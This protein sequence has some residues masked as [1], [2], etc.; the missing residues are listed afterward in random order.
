MLIIGFLLGCPLFH[1]A[2]ELK[3]VVETGD[4]N[5]SA[6]VLIVANKKKFND[7]VILKVTRMLRKEGMHVQLA[8]GTNLKGIRANKYGAIIIINFIEDK[9][10][11]RSIE[12]FADERVQK[13]IVLF[14][15]VGDY[16]TSDKDR[17]SSKTEKSEKI[18]L[19]IIERTKIILS[20]QRNSAEMRDGVR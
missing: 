20:N 18:A 13:K 3:M 11:D 9:R 2:A 12:I 10:N 1:A 5:S 7:P 19:E 14:N 15:A 8:T 16:L 17:A 4:K 6:N